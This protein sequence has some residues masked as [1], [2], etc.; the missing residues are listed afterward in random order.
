[1][2]GAPLRSISY[3]W[4][5]FITA[6]ETARYF[7]SRGY[8]GLRILIGLV[9]FSRLRIV[10]FCFFLF[11]IREMTLNKLIEYFC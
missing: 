4:L 8:F 5:G 9:K 10:I 3:C 7:E 1:M 11:E 6:L 2:L